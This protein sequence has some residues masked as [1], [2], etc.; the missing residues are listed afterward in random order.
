M[1]LPIRYEDEIEEELI[2]TDDGVEWYGNIEDKPQIEQNLQ[3]LQ[4][5]YYATNDIKEKQKIWSQMF[6]LTQVYAKSLIMKRMKGVRYESPEEID[7]K[8]NQTALA[9]MSQYCYRKGFKCGASFAGMISPKILESLYGHCK[10]DQVMSLNK[11]IGTSDKEI[12]D[13]QEFFGFKSIYEQPDEFAQVITTSLREILDKLLVEFDS[14]VE[15]ESRRFKLRAYLQI[16]LRKP[17]N[18]HSKLLFL[19]NFCDKKDIDVIRLF[20]LELYN[21]LSQEYYD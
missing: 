15:D 5:D 9:F 21:R 6:V 1:M 3:A 7:D 4:T 17:R 19:R 20:E 18:K 12:G 16:L 13:A 14:E 10:E 11:T 8:A 2:F